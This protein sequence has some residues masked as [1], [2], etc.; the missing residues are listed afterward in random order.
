MLDIVIFIL[1]VI[2]FLYVWERRNL[3]QAIVVGSGVTTFGVLLLPNKVLYQFYFHFAGRWYLINIS[4][5]TIKVVFLISFCIALGVIKYK[6][7]DIGD[8]V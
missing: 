7:I 1:V 3:Y 5:N 8:M 6:N 4:M 2:T